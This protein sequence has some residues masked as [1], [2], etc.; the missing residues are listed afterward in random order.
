LQSGNAVFTSGKVGIG[1]DAPTV[2]LHVAGSLATE[3]IQFSDGT[4][5]TSTANLGNASTLQ[6]ADGNAVVQVASDGK[7]GIGT[8]SPSAELEVAGDLAV[9]GTL[10]LSVQ[11]D[12]SMGAFTTGE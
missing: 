12:L 9:Q 4:T 10:I 3:Q 6:D 11:G 2:E 8:D 5:L 7:V 1:T